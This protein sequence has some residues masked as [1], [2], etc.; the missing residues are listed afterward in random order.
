MLSNGKQSG[1]LILRRDDDD[2][3]VD[4][5]GGG[6]GAAFN[7]AEK[8]LKVYIHLDQQPHTNCQ[9]LGPALAQSGLVYRNPAYRGGLLVEHEGRCQ[10]FGSAKQL[11]PY[12][13]D[14]LDVV[15]LNE[16]KRKGCVIPSPYLDLMLATET[17]LDCFRPVDTVTAVPGFDSEF[18]LLKPGYNPGPAG[19][20]IY[21]TGSVIQPATRT[22]TIDKFLDVM[23]FA[24]EADRTAAVAGALTI[25][26][27]RCWPGGKAMVLARATKSQSG[28]ETLLDF[29]CGLTPSFA[30]TFQPDKDWPMEKN[31]AAILDRNPESGVIRL[32][33]IRIDGRKREIS[34]AF[35]ERFLTSNYVTLYTTGTGN[36]VPVPNSFVVA[37]SSNEGIFSVD[38]LNRSL[39]MMLTAKGDMAARVSR[40]GDPR[41]E[42]LP[43][44][45]NTIHAELLGIVCRWSQAGRPLDL[46][47]MKKHCFKQ[48]AAEVGGMLELAGY[49]EF[50]ENHMLQSSA[51]NP[52]KEKLAFL[53]LMAGSDWLRPSE[54]LDIAEQHAVATELI[55]HGHREGHERRLTG[56]GKTLSS[57]EN[58]TLTTT[59]EDEVVTF[60]LIK[61]RKRMRP[62]EDAKVVYQFEEL[63]RKSLAV[64]D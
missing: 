49:R 46:T 54:L 58:E 38:F 43:A 34:S 2:D 9:V 11:A 23:P 22:D 45:R 36:P 56:L 20:R 47:A 59:T 17:F 15:V 24:T 41:W 37:A 55:P 62:G 52:T 60:R 27:R 32:E 29:T 30:L 21:Y 14:H 35:F 64:S 18:G 28:K 42:Y 39:T 33:N 61:E 48:W 50:L 16:D 25:L 26:L 63:S 13:A 44:N 10:E 19:H 6:G 12:I 8:R 40:I 51:H 31:V 3:V 1:E 5:G 7:T 53:G 57:H 4:V